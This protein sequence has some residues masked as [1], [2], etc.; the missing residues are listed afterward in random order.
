M[1]NT[2]SPVSSRHGLILT[3]LLLLVVVAAVIGAA[4]SLLSS[5]PFARAGERTPTA[6]AAAT[7]APGDRPSLAIS[8]EEGEPGTRIVAV[9]RGWR[10][11]DTVLI[12]LEA[13]GAENATT[14]EMASAIVSDR[15]EFSVR[16]TYPINRPWDVLPVVKV[17]AVDETAHQRISTA[18]R[19]TAAQLTTVT[20]APTET[21]TATELPPTL[22]STPTAQP[23]RPTSTPYPPP[24]ILPTVA[25]WPTAVPWPTAA[26][27]PTTA[28][29]PTPVPPTPVPPIVITGWRGEYFASINPYGQPALIRNDAAIDFNWGL[30]SP[31]PGLPADNFSVRWL[32]KQDFDTA[33]YRFYLT[34]DDGARVWVDGQIVLDEWHDGSVRE[35]YADYPLTRGEHTVQVDYYEHLGGAEIKLWW[36]RLTPTADP[37]LDG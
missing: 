21:P 1:K 3:T 34:V 19:M 36:E 11:G 29:W 7:L 16:F 28:P 9:G 10:P 4:L 30:G 15:G 26:P 22:T 24:I 25:P 2:P 13:P 5:S 37:R 23:P 17:T 8:P 35:V 18:F 33:T 27:W 6:T 31:A 20:P 12:R 32:R 14:Q